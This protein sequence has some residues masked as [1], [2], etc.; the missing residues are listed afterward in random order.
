MV[1][2]GV[3]G[4]KEVR[5]FPK[6]LGILLSSAL[7]KSDYPFLCWLT[8]LNANG[9]FLQYSGA[10]FSS[11]NNNTS[12]QLAHSLSLTLQTNLKLV[13]NDFIHWTF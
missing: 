5:L 4:G 2:I 1:P 10:N 6:L 7:F 12:R 3:Q 11:Q 9:I 13:L 8:L